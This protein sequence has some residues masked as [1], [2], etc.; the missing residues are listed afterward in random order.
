MAL[1]PK[2]LCKRLIRYPLRR[3]HR[4]GEQ[5]LASGTPRSDV[6]ANQQSEVECVLRLKTLEREVCCIGAVEPPQFAVHRS[7]VIHAERG[8]ETQA[9]EDQARLFAKGLEERCPS[10][11]VPAA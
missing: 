10:S 1:E 2:A 11:I 9:Q 8:A 6:C 5:L 7:I 3:T 4:E